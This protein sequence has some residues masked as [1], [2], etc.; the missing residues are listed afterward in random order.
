MY[1]VALLKKQPEA[2]KKAVNDYQ[3]KLEEDMMKVAKSNDNTETPITDYWKHDP[4][5]MNNINMLMFKSYNNLKEADGSLVLASKDTFDNWG[6]I[7][8]FTPHVTFQPRSV[9]GVQNI[10]KWAVAHNKRVRTAGY[11][12][13]WSNIFGDDGVVVISLLKIEVVEELPAEHPKMEKG[14]EFQFLR[15]VGE[16]YEVDGIIRRNCEIGTG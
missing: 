5:H 13:S 6:R 7:V 1:N 12:H 11:R 15:L 16:E 10:M 8:R 3:T 2:I 14:N 9:V 4:L